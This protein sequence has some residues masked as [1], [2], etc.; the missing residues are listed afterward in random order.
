MPKGFF[1]RVIP[2]MSFSLLLTKAM[3]QRKSGIKPM[4]YI[5]IDEV[6]LQATEFEDMLMDISRPISRY[7]ANYSYSIASPEGTWKCI[8]FKCLHDLRAL[9]VYTSGRSLPL[10]A[11][12][13]E[14]S[15]SPDQTQARELYDT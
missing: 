10:Y 8:E 15:C 14:V 3:H 1:S 11:A 9:V 6:Y 4:E 2:N 5:I 13:Q 12:P 7:G